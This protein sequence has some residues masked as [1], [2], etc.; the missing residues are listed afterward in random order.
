MP[1]DEAAFTSSRS[2]LQ[3][4]F[5]HFRP[6]LGESLVFFGLRS[7]FCIVL[8][9]ACTALPTYSQT[10]APSPT[11]VGPATTQTP[12]PQTA[13]AAQPVKGGPLNAEQVAEATILFYGFPSG[14]DT[15][16]Q[17]RKTTQERGRVRVQTAEGK[18]ENV[19]YQRFVIR[20]ESLDKERVRLDQEFPN[21]RFS[22][23]RADDKIFGLY[24][25]TVFALPRPLRTR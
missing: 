15:L 22:L 5:A 24:N 4:A 16:N 21:A 1:A 17:I 25:N 20:A 12:S 23:V 19:P 11:P 13:A 18:L 3:S 10:P 8:L 2:M 6:S 9:S 7:L 14:R